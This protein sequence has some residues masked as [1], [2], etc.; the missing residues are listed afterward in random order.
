MPFMRVIHGRQEHSD[1]YRSPRSIDYVWLVDPY[2][3]QHSLSLSLSLSLPNQAR[4][5]PLNHKHNTGTRR[6]ETWRFHR[7]HYYDP[8]LALLPFPVD[9]D[10]FTFTDPS[11]LFNK[12][13]E[14]YLLLRALVVVDRQGHYDQYRYR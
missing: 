12:G 6:D 7:V 13:L 14:K 5:P 11:G 9:V 8:L 10:S 3:H 4:D 2:R 1:E